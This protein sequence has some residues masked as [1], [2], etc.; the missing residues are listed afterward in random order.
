MSQ[1]QQLLSSGAQQ[2]MVRYSLLSVHFLS[3]ESFF[4]EAGPNAKWYT[5]NTTVRTEYSKLA[6]FA[7]VAIVCITGMST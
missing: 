2:I 4:S 6:G 5:N 1:A 7:G 3:I